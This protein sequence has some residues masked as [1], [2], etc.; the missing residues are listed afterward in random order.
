MGDGKALQ[1]GTSHDLGQN[2]AKV[3]DITYLDDQGDTQ[4][5]H[6]TSWGVTTRM[7]GGLIMAHGDDNG[8]R[9]PPAVAPVQAMIVP[10][11]GKT[12]DETTSVRDAVDELRDA[13]A[14]RRWRDAPVRVKVDDSDVDVVH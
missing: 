4:L 8:L 5:C 3:F 6:T 14:A 11:P 9:L 13:I 7:V 2:F 1:M 12:D 10:I